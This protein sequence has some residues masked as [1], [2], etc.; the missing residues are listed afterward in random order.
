MKEKIRS[1]LRHPLISGSAI[2][3]LGTNVGNVFNF[4]FNLFMVRNLTPVD[5]GVLVGLIALITLFAQVADSITPFIVN[6]AAI[7][8]AVGELG[9]AKTLFFKAMKLSTAIGIGVLL[10][11]I[12]FAAPIGVFL[13]IQNPITIMIA[14]FCILFGFLSTLNRAFLQ[15]KLA[16][17]Y[18]AIIVFVGSLIKFGSGVFF[19]DLGL[20]VQGALFAF[21]LAFFVPYLISFI[22]LRQFLHPSQQKEKVEL[23]KMM[24]FGVGSVLTIFAITAFI[25]TDIL[26][27]K[28]FFLPEEAGLYAG[29][30]IMGKIVYFFS[31]PIVS[32]MFP[33]I[34]QKYAKQQNYHNDFRFALLLVFFP[35]IVLTL[36]YFFMPEFVIRFVMKRES[37][38]ETASYIGYMGIFYTLYAAITLVANFFLSIQRSHI[39]L[40]IL[41]FALLQGGGIWFLHSSPVEVL[42]VSI[43]TSGLLLLTLL[44]YYIKIS[45]RKL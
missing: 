36:L 5:Y 21:I 23:R 16:F 41:F 20:G 18:L 8:F 4:L 43:S 14:G 37:Y 39:Y 7:Y 10:M 42:M 38:L 11:F 45:F 34:V 13:K 26:L 31:A 1:T 28:H 35:S 27:V 44:L 25:T 24:R 30:T 12:V 40:P 15:A 2:I 33:L 29:S 32:V 17:T 3:F 22:P 19:I 9:K 6:Y